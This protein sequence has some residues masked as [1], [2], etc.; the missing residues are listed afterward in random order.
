MTRA[1][2]TNLLALFAAMAVVFGL[3]WLNDDEPDQSSAPTPKGDEAEP[4]QAT[5][6]P[7]KPHECRI[8]IPGQEIA[9]GV[10]PTEDGLDEYVRAAAQGDSK[11][12]GVAIRANRAFFVQRN[13]RCSYLDPGIATSKVRI[14]EGA[15]EGRAGWLVTEWTTGSP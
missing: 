5:A 15:H 3:A 1:N 13:T 10:F 7:P 8:S 6:D 11:A 9:V 14:L 2:L 12:A 4:Q